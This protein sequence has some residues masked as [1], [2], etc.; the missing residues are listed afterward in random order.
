MLVHLTTLYLVQKMKRAF[1]LAVALSVTV[2]LLHPAEATLGIDVSASTSK[3]A[4]SCLKGQGYDFLIVRG[5]RSYGEPD[6]S[7]ASTIANAKAAGIGNADVYMFPCPKC[8]KSAREQ[9]NEMGE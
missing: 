2:S 7:A 3:S 1:F 5:Y 8:S 9:V 4:F 6:G